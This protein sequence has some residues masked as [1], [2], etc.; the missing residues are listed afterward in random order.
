M[1][2]NIFIDV[3][4]AQKARIVRKDCIKITMQSTFIISNNNTR[5]RHVE[6]F[7]YILEMFKCLNIIL[8]FFCNKEAE[9]N[10]K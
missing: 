5:I 10:V 4:H 7:K 3:S 1:T 9:H 2:Q 6:F 8:L